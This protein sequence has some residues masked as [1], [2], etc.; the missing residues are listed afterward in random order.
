MAFSIS[1]SHISIEFIPPNY[2]LV[3][4]ISEIGY[5]IDSLS[6]L[7]SQDVHNILS[8]PEVLSEIL[9]LLW[10]LIKSISKQKKD[11]IN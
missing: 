9:M 10:P 6:Y 8:I 5:I 11:L 7:K 4:V 2:C 3:L 1:M